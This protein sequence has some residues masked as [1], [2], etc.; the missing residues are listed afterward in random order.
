MTPTS[1]SHLKLSCIVQGGSCQVKHMVQPIFNKAFRFYTD[2]KEPT[3][4]CWHCGLQKVQVRQTLWRIGAIL[5]N[6]LMPSSTLA[7]QDSLQGNR[8]VGETLFK[9][10]LIQVMGNLLNGLNTQTAWYCMFNSE[11][12]FLR[13][14]VFWSEFNTYPTSHLQL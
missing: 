10:D 4:S 6:V 2:F 3:A 5:A 12:R 8:Q 13:E 14:H 1:P 7:T 11:S 9:I